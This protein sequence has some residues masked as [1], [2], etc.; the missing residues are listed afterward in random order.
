MTS[1]RW[2]RNL[3]GFSLSIEFTKGRFVQFCGDF[4]GGLL[5]FY[6][7]RSK[8]SGFTVSITFAG[9]KGKVVEFRDALVKNVS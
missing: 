9:L 7:Y 5:G 2:E 8:D 6:I 1:A 3:T 4:G